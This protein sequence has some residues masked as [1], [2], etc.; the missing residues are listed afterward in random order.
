MDRVSVVTYI[1]AGGPRLPPHTTPPTT[2]MRRTTRSHRQLCDGGVM[3][4]GQAWAI[5]RSS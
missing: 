1:D 2:S 4:V 3:K 5:I